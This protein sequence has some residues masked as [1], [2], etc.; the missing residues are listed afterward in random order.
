M[1]TAST[2]ILL[3]HIYLGELRHD[4]TQLAVDLHELV[5]RGFGTLP[6]RVQLRLSGREAVLR[7]PH[8]KLRLPAARLEARIREEGVRAEERR[9]GLEVRLARERDDLLAL[10]GDLFGK[11]FDGAPAPW[12]HDLAQLSRKLSDDAIHE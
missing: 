10:R 2:H 5:R 4:V 12:R 11:L 8:P 3:L 9:A 7:A 6:A 1:N